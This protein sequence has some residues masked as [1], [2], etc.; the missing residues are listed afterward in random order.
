MAISLKELSEKIA[1]SIPVGTIVA[2]YGTTAPS[3]WLICDGRSCAGTALA[4][5]I[6]KTSTPDLRGRFI[7]MVGGMAA[8]MGV[9]QDQALGPHAHKTWGDINGAF[10][11]SA[12]GGWGQSVGYPY[13]RWRNT[14]STGTGMADETRPVNMAFNYIIRA[15]SYYD[16]A[17]LSHLNTKFGGERR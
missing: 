11:F 9:E 4:S 1:A 17:I 12:G 8:E 10:K 6:G 3:G 16:I 5:L 14:E 2:Y 7:R 13:N 15:I